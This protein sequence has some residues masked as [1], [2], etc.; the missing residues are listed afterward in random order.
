MCIRDRYTAAVWIGNDVN[1]EL[2]EGSAAAARLWRTIMSQVCAGE[3]RGKYPSKPDN[4]S[5]IGGEYYTDGTYSR[6]AKPKSTSDESESSSSS[7]KKKGTTKRVER[8][9]TQPPATQ[10]PTQA[11]TTQAPTTKAPTTNTENNGN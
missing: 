4:V 10:A 3:P 1:I 11:P 9:T 5:N 8:A 6:V 7:E 2:A